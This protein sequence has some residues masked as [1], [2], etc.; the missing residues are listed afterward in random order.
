MGGE[1]SVLRALSGVIR[2]PYH[3]FTSY[4]HVDNEPEPSHEGFVTACVEYLEHRLVDS[5]G[6]HYAEFRDADSGRVIFR[7][8]EGLGACDQWRQRML[9]HAGVAPVHLV[10]ASEGYFRSAVCAQEWCQHKQYSR[11]ARRAQ[12]VRHATSAVVVI[13]LAAQW[14]SEPSTLACECSRQCVESRTDELRRIHSVE[15]DRFAD[16]K[17]IYDQQRGEPHDED[18]PLWERL[19]EG[20]CEA[21]AQIAERIA[22][23][24][25]THAVRVGSPTNCRWQSTHYVERPEVMTRITDTFFGPAGRQ[26]V[27][28]LYGLGGLGKTE[29]AVAVAREYAPEFPAG[30]WMVTCRNHTHIHAAL[31][32]LKGHPFFAQ[33]TQN[34]TAPGQAV[35]DVLVKLHDGY[36]A[37]KAGTRSSGL[38]EQAVGSVGHSAGIRGG[39]TP[40][41]G[42]VADEGSMLLICDNV[43]NADMMRSIQELACRAPWLRVLATSRSNHTALGVVDE[44]AVEIPTM[45]QDRSVEFLSMF[46]PPHQP[47]AADGIKDVAD[48]LKGF[49]LVLEQ[50]GAY[51]EN[52]AGTESYRDYLRR[53]EKYG[54]TS[55]GDVKVK[56]VPGVAVTIEH[57]QQL[58]SAVLETTFNSLGHALGSTS[59]CPARDTRQ[60]AFEVLRMAAL[61]PSEHISW[62]FLR[63][64]LIQRY[65]TE[66]GRKTLWRFWD[67]AHSSC[68]HPD[69]VDELWVDIRTCLTQHRLITDVTTGSQNYAGTASDVAD[70]VGGSGCVVGVMHSLT[71]Q[72]LTG[73]DQ[74]DLTR[75]DQTPD[76]AIPVTAADWYYLGEYLANRCCHL[77]DTYFWGRTLD[78]CTC[79]SLSKTLADLINRLPAPGGKKQFCRKQW[80]I[81]ATTGQYSLRH[82]LSPYAGST[83][84]ETIYEYTTEHWRQLV[85]DNPGHRD[86]HR[87]LS[88]TL[89]AHARLA[90]ER[91]DLDHAHDLYVEATNIRQ[92]LVLDAPEHCDYRQGLAITLGDHARLLHERGD[93]DHADA[94]FTHATYLFQELVREKPQS[95]DYRQGYGV[96]LGH[97][98]RLVHAR[99]DLDHADTLLSKAT[100]AVRRLVNQD[101]FH[102]HYRQDLGITLGVHAQLLHERG[103]LIR[104][105]A[106]YADAT[107]IF[108]ELVDQN[109]DHRH[110]RQDLG[111][112]LKG[113]AQ[114]MQQRDRLDRADTFYT[115]ATS[116]FHELATQ[117]PDHRS[118]QRDL[119]ITLNDHA[120]CKAA[121]GEGHQATELTTQALGVY[122]S[123]VEENK[124]PWHVDE[125]K[126]LLDNARSFLDEPDCE[127]H[128]DA[129]KDNLDTAC[130]L[131][132]K[133]GAT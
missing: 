114:L 30:R 33:R 58:L 111:T 97:H 51:I 49:T 10:F 45:T 8:S 46:V 52:N 79:F 38:V 57:S 103:D 120:V 22:D 86:Y 50:A 80:L 12:G 82:A 90:R 129:L 31:A 107:V 37:Q 25:V 93:L 15:Y 88:I 85:A 2:L 29:L 68:Y 124:L 122:T 9:R 117:H 17:A 108:R 26:P 131:L 115:E 18:V 105:D 65:C 24:L 32:D 125:L 13:N 92:R 64:A 118:Y 101:P 34:T 75:P 6:A 119:G 102:D 43:D 83:G 59:S 61:L 5:L 71:Q 21:L 67:D 27:V 19:P 41:V 1:Q 62:D 78:A 16:F 76:T 95:C 4:A 121:C 100:N 91:G 133:L 116:I 126:A 40:G 3:V 23:Y 7:D 89:N 110:Y 39:A 55:Y 11:M 63:G 106:L 104:A 42:T 81:A 87:Q 98:A 74:A 123:L 84:W 72:Y 70:N 54:V 20:A 77:N 96:T 128:T 53:L 44:C 94:L 35:E 112:T 60:M 36:L 66:N 69:V 28:L 48:T 109:P 130:R 132:E 56:T 127:Q 14:P 47:E 73:N 113:R 99:G